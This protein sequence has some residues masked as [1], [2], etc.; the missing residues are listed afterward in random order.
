MKKVAIINKYLPYY[1]LSVYNQLSK[2]SEP[3]YE[4][5]GDKYGREGIYTIPLK[6]SKI[7]P[8]EGGINWSFSTSYYY[9]KSLQLF[10]T[11]IISKIFPLLEIYTTIPYFYRQI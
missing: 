3:I 7:K 8:K 1:R 6:Y 5:F 4:I 11:N 10:Q 2:Y 9:S